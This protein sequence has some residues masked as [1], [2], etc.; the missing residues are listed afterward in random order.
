MKGKGAQ[1]EREGSPILCVLLFS[2][3]KAKGGSRVRN[4]YFILWMTLMTS[5]RYLKA[6]SQCSAVQCN[7]L[8]NNYNNETSRPQT[9]DQ[10][11]NKGFIHSLHHLSIDSR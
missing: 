4:A 7:T 10:A 1:W 2:K 5:V 6:T 9:Y 3:R 8:L 11:H